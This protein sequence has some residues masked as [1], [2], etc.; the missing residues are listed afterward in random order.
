MPAAAQALAEHGADL[1][2]N[3]A[4][5]WTTRPAIDWERLPTRVEAVIA[6]RIGRLPAGLRM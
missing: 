5:F 3:P 4:G 6:E 1:V 2:R